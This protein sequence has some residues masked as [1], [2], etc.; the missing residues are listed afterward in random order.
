MHRSS[1]GALKELSHALNAKSA[2]LSRVSAAVGRVARIC[3]CP[4]YYFA[5]FFLGAELLGAGT[6]APHAFW[7]IQIHE[8]DGA[9][10][11]AR[12]PARPA[13]RSDVER[14]QWMLGVTTLARENSDAQV[15]F[16]GERLNPHGAVS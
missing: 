12:R 8:P 11:Y 4:L 2:D 3:E 7:V 5:P 13:W 15:G 10:R 16:R 6:L 9:T 1:A 14:L